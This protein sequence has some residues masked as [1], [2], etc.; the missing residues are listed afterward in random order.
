[1]RTSLIA[2]LVAVGAAGTLWFTGRTYVVS[3]EGHVTER[4]TDA[5]TQIGDDSLEVRLGG[6][7]ALARIGWDS[8][9]DP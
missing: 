5:V 6:V 4:Y 8:E 7:Y 2:F 1:M 9:K 3:R